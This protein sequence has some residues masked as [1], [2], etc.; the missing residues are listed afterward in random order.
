MLGGMVQFEH[1]ILFQELL[2]GILPGAPPMSD[3]G[4]SMLQTLNIAS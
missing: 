3:M 4:G 2:V 1:A